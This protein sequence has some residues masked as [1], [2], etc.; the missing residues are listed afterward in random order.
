M[1]NI[2]IIAILLFSGYWAY[3]NY[4]NT[5]SSL[6]NQVASEMSKQ[7]PSM[8]KRKVASCI[9]DL[10]KKLSSSQLAVIEEM[11]ESGTGEVNQ[12]SLLSLSNADQEAVAEA[13]M[14]IVFCAMTNS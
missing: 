10:F 1:K 2:I 5:S 14:G 4:F 7:T 6:A 8:N 13:M 11:I 3:N 12:S 9:N